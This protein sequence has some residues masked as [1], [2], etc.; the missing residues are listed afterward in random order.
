MGKLWS[1]QR[2][3]AEVPVGEQWEI[4]LDGKLGTMVWAALTGEYV[5][6]GEGH[7]QPLKKSKMWC[8]S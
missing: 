5:V 4:K 7:L 8:F 3:L 1:R 2:V 6:D